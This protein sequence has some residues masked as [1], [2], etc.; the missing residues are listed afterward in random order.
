ML[1]LNLV[2]FYVPFRFSQRTIYDDLTD[3]DANEMLEQANLWFNFNATPM[4]LYCYYCWTGGAIGRLEAFTFD[5]A[6][7]GPN[8][9]CFCCVRCA[10]S[11][12]TRSISNNIGANKIADELKN[13]HAAEHEYAYNPFIQLHKQV[14]T[15]YPK[16]RTSSG[17]ISV[18]PNNL[19][20]KLSSSSS[21]SSSGRSD[22]TSGECASLLPMPLS[23]WSTSSTSSTLDI[24]SWD[25][26]C[27]CGN[28]RR[29]KV[30]TGQLWFRCRRAS[31]QTVRTMA[32]V[33]T[34]IQKNP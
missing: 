33:R 24:V 26:Y 1:F 22:F 29:C 30:D 10:S 12:C 21:S 13:I 17:N 18:R 34:M 19:S 2:Y 32:H 14:P 27:T 31:F 5:M 9:T 6:L 28:S 4:V 16:L 8:K 7:L 20:A 3:V 23:N 25:K 15:L 11:I